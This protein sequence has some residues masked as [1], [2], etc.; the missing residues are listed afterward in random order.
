V[1]NGFIPTGNRE[2]F[3]GENFRIEPR[4]IFDTAAGPMFRASL[5][6]GFLFREEQTIGNLQVGNALTFGFGADLAPSEQ[7]HVVPEL[8]GEAALLGDEVSSEEVPLEA[9]LGFKIYPVDILLI[10][11][12]GGVGVVE[13]YGTPDARVFFGLH[14]SP[15]YG[16]RDGDGIYDNED[17]CPDDPEDFDGFEDVEGCPDPDN[18]QDQI[19]DVDDECPNDPEDYDKFEDEDGCPDPDNDQDTISTSMICPMDRKTTASSTRTA[20]PTVE[21][22][23]YGS[24][25]G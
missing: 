4:L 10:Q 20:A 17:S 2:F 24:V 19:L 12:G 21:N 15:A 13:G 1:V 11:L 5:N 18:D 23:G 7:F 14:L 25:R 3:Q 22:P 9:R 6:V 8:V 16:D